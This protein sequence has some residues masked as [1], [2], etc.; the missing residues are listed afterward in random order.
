[1]RKWKDVANMLGKVKAIV[2]RSRFGHEFFALGM[3]KAL[4]L[5][6]LIC[7]KKDEEEDYNKEAEGILAFM[8][9]FYGDMQIVPFA[10][11]YK[12]DGWDIVKDLC[13][14]VLD[15]KIWD[16]FFS[17]GVLDLQPSVNRLEFPMNFNLYWPIGLVPDKW[18][19][20]GQ[21][22]KTAEEQSSG[23]SGYKFLTNE[24]A[25][26]LVIL[27]HFNKV[28]DLE[29]VKATA[30]ALAGEY[31]PN[32][33]YIP[34]LEDGNEELLGLRGVPHV[35]YYNLYAHL[36]GLVGIP[37]THTWIAATLFPD[38]PQVI[39]YRRGI[40]DWELIAEKAYDHGRSY[41]AVPFDEDS[42]MKEV[43]G[44]VEKICS[45]IF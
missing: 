26:D 11:R 37:G 44:K 8:S 33:A 19:T 17:E 45:D 40:E 36:E 25:N 7:P 27:Q 23:V 16:I 38:M 10:N 34:G 22:G 35:K 41:H 14:K 12:V 4:R 1:M 30:K 9:P 5:K 6:V 21:C 15:D 2:I 13:D 18:E 43:F 32:G 3:A 29:K 28:A 39:V 42:D 24:F 20:D 31:S